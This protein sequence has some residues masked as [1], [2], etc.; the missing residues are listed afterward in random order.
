MK[1]EQLNVEY[2]SD[3][4][5]TNIEGGGFWYETFYPVGYTLVYGLVKYVKAQE[6]EFSPNL[7]GPTANHG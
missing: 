3:K 7:G 1:K 4:E 6:R 2:L 5:M